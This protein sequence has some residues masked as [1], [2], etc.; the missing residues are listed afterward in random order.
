MEENYNPLAAL[1]PDDEQQE[2]DDTPVITSTSEYNPLAA[3]F[4]DDTEVVQ[5]EKETAEVVATEQPKELEEVEYNPL[6]ALFG[7]DPLATQTT[8]DPAE[9]NP[10]YALDVEKTFDE[11]AKDQ[12]YV[13]SVK[14][15]AISRYGD[16][17]VEQLEGKSNEEVLELF[18]SEVR[19]FET[20][21]LNLSSM[22][23]YVRGASE[24]DK[25]NFGF[26]YSQLEK[27]P[28]FMSEGGGSAISAVGD[29][30]K[31][32]VSD[33]INL[34]GFGAG[35]VA[36]SGAKQAILQ[37]FK[38]KGKEAAI[39]EAGKLS[40]QAAKKPIAVEAGFDLVAGTIE[41]LGRQSVKK[42]VGIIDDVSVGEAML[43]G[44]F[45]AVAGGIA[46]V[47]MT[48]ATARS[49]AKEIVD[50]AE[51][52]G[53][54]IA[55]RAGAKELAE[56][57]DSGY[58]FDPINGYEVLEEIDLKSLR[59]QVAGG[60]LTEGQLQVEITQRVAKAASDIVADMMHRGE[61]VPAVQKMIDDGNKASE[62]A[63]TILSNEDID[64]DLLSGA[65]KRAGMSVEDFLDV[66]GVSLTDA[67]KTMASYSNMGKLI[68]RTNELDPVA[69]KKIEDA[70]GKED[71]TVSALTKAH[72]F[73]MRLDRERR[74]FM[75][76]QIATT[77][78]NVATAGMRLGMESAA[79]T[80]ESS[81]Y[82]LG[83]GIGAVGRGDASFEGFQKGLRQIAVDGF[84]TLAYLA[85]AGG[86]KEL[87]NTLLKH[88]PRLARIM[89]RSLQEV[90]VDQTLSKPARLVNT[91]NMLQDTYFRRAVFNESVAKQ[92]RATGI[93]LDDFLLTGKALPS[94]VM[95]RA[96][97]EALSFTFARMPKRGGDRVGDTIGHHLIRINEALGPLPGVVG[98]PVGT[99]AFP[100]GRFMFN[101]MQFQL[102]Y[103]PLSTVGAITNGSKGMFNKYVRGISDAKTERQLA[104]ARE[105]VGKAT[106]G[107]AAL[108]AAIKYREENQDTKWY[109]FTDSEGRPVDTR[110]FFPI[111]PYLAVADF[112]VKLKNNELDEAGIKQVLEGLT[113]AQLRSGASSYMID[114]FFENLESVTGGSDGGGD[115]KIE[116]MAE[117]VGGYLGELVGAFTTPAKM[118]GDVMAQFDKDEAMIRDARQIEGVGAAE[119][120]VDAFEK[121]AF[122]GVPGL[123]GELPV[124]ESPTQTD[125]MIKQSPLLGQLTGVR[126]Q[127]RR[128]DVQKE[129]IDLG[130]EDYEIVPSTG[131]KAADAFVKRIMGRFV[132][133][134]LA[135]EISR[136]GYQRLSDAKKKASMRNKLKRYRDISK[137]VGEAEASRGS[138]KEGKAFTPF[139]RA[140][141][142]KL[143]KGA[144]KLADEYY[145]ERYGMSVL[146]KQA[147]EPNVNHFL[148][149]KKIGSTL[150]RV[151]K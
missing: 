76:S 102:D 12:G 30:L 91:L 110:A 6:A 69:A 20:N 55:E 17:A 23:D 95:E 86:S 51:A 142:A 37:A 112:I 138:R 77:A 121:A 36:A 25:Q 9:Y 119:R 88:N 129:L 47:G 48:A 141:W 120:G 50:Q 11:F 62:I 43:I 150:N 38:T 135:R 134:N 116:K 137:K 44:G 39:K 118:V 133:D 4:G 3:L 139:D 85:D 143:S 144:R 151:M 136:P 53:T 140:Q 107:T 145:M 124:K 72:D 56:Q 96:V 2:T 108:F 130:Y 132:E 73:M 87:A 80:M 98:I 104:K 54:K 131:D 68:K 46:T 41:D 15:Y 67:A 32:F 19:S 21:S 74:A 90:D 114:S 63:R 1:F 40:L 33:P 105:Q 122:R 126:P 18:L 31:F 28:G 27:M 5:A 58:V 70:F 93:D 148:V 83:K 10:D 26:V 149:G 71:A 84:G 22:I 64:S 111:S 125:P 24:K 61:I 16:T 65:L 127:K 78:R 106:V 117:Y 89:D 59:S 29:Y 34:V 109:E 45:Q 13:D 123:S 7:D 82:H 97:D 79:K 75:V 100:F 8:E 99:G 101:A 66:S 115:I 49:G 81:L 113:G 52:I 60:E 14:E 103:S 57:Q 42:E 92:L 128:T 94:K 147:E 35:R 146:D